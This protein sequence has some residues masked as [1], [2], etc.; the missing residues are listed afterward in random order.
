MVIKSGR[1]RKSKTIKYPIFKE[2]A[3]I[4]D[5]PYWKDKFEKASI[6]RFPK[7]F[8]YRNGVISKKKNNRV[9]KLKIGTDPEMVANE[10]IEFFKIH[11]L[12][13]SN[14]DISGTVLTNNIHLF[15]LSEI[16]WSKLNAAVKEKLIHKY[17]ETVNQKY[18]FSN[19]KIDEIITKINVALNS[20]ILTQNSFEFENGELLSIKDVEF[21]NNGIKFNAQKSVRKTKPKRAVK[22]IKKDSD[23]DP[24][25][26]NNFIEGW[27]KYLN[28]IYNIYVKYDNFYHSTRSFDTSVDDINN[29]SYSEND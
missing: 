18:S 2:C 25:T 9:V 1:G 26:Q 27:N 24:T 4:T 13:I 29:I 10:C 23:K 14:H 15:R 3:D 5:D 22:N 6:G 8:I 16:P 17:I 20:S 19:D 7:T 21:D 12:M 11:G 28:Y